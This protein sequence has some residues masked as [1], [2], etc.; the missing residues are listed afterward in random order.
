MM[1]NVHADLK[2]DI[3]GAFEEIDQKYSLNHLIRH[4]KESENKMTEEQVKTV[5]NIL[6][7]FS[8][9]NM[10]SISFGQE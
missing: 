1:M 4:V 2:G 8:C 5:F 6:F 9:E 3:T 7:N 10:P